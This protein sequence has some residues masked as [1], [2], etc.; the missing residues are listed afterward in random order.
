[1]SQDNQ[2][3][4]NEEGDAQPRRRLH[5]RQR[6]GRV[7]NRTRGFVFRSGEKIVNGTRTAAHITHVLGY[8]AYERT[9]DNLHA[10]FPKQI[11]APVGEL[12]VEARKQFRIFRLREDQADEEITG[13]ANSTRIINT[14]LR[15]VGL[16]HIDYGTN[17]QGPWDL[18]ADDI[19]RIVQESGQ[20]PQPYGTARPFVGDYRGWVNGRMQFTVNIMQREA[21][22]RILDIIHLDAARE[23]L[24]MTLP[25]M[26][27]IIHAD[28]TVGANRYRLQCHV[29]YV[30]WHGYKHLWDTN[31]IIIKQQE[32]DERQALSPLAAMALIY[33]LRDLPDKDKE[34]WGLYTDSINYLFFHVD[35]QGLYS[36]RAYFGGDQR[37]YQGFRLWLKI[38]D[39]AYAR[40][41]RIRE[42]AAEPMT[43]LQIA[44]TPETIYDP[45]HQVVLETQGALL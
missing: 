2:V 28:F 38:Y 18:G 13:R 3:P 29:D 36:K 22:R 25:E 26:N 44:R 14:F 6:V 39:Q 4:Q 10:A 7:A 11:R 40:A 23:T 8:R 32:Y 30:L 19:H 27:Q 41:R 15:S 35:N 12:L 9:F 20:M 45:L 42:R 31:L 37:L 1:M 24:K 34:T 16:R 21:A 43:E 33:H 5:I 17:E